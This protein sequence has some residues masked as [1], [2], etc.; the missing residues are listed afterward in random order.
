MNGRLKPADNIETAKLK[1]KTFTCDKCGE[2]VSIKAVEFAEV[3][4]CGICGGL[5]HEVV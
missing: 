2:T 1:A 4:T 5:M 3:L